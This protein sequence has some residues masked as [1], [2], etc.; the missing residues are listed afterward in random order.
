MFTVSSGHT[1]SEDDSHQ[2]NLGN[3]GGGCSR[4]FWGQKA[5]AVLGSSEGSRAD[6]LESS[7]ETHARWRG[8]PG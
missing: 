5:D 3:E 2:C 8:A 1:Q 6:A 4:L 7:A